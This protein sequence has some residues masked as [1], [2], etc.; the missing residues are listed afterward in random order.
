MKISGGMSWSRCGTQQV[1]DACLPGELNP[2]AAISI[3]RTA[4]P[5]T[6]GNACK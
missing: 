3:P 6:T 4:S 2:T 5:A 1:Q